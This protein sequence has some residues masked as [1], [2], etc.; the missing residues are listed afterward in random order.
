MKKGFFQKLY[1]FDKKSKTYLIEVSLDDYDDV[2]DDW[3]PSPFKKRD[4][5]DEFSDFILDSSMDIPLTFN[6]TLVLYL[7]QDKKDERKEST[8]IAAFRNYYQYA[9]ERHKRANSN[10]NNRTVF[11]L[12]LSLFLLGI[13]YFFSWDTENIIYNIVHE[14][15]FVGGWVFLW[16]FF[17]NIFIKKRELHRQYRLYKRLLQS[18]IRF[19][20]VS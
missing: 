10:L 14:G 18:E 6:I 3:D 20:Y 12:C 19:E 8:L 16:E 15:I 9:I 7:P 2:F 11:Y 1:K 4:I 17:T 5:E 13:G